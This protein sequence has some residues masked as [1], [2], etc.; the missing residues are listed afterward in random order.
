MSSTTYSFQ[1][2][3][4]NVV[5]LSTTTGEPT[6]FEDEFSSKVDI[7]EYWAKASYEFPPEALDLSLEFLFE[8]LSSS[9][10]A[11]STWYYSDNSLSLLSRDVAS[12]KKLRICKKV[13][14]RLMTS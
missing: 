2:T 1:Y 12:S 10:S 14:W 9:L 11:V 6:K 13:K 4:E 8:F 5:S 3:S 7:S